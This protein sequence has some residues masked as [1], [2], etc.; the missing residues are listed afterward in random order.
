MRYISTIEDKNIIIKD[1]IDNEEYDVKDLDINEL[2]YIMG[3]NFSSEV[4]VLQE[5]LKGRV[6]FGNRSIKSHHDLVTRIETCY[7]IITSVG[8]DGNISTSPIMKESIIEAETDAI[9][10]TVNNRSECKLV[11]QHPKSSCSI[12]L[13][14]KTG[15]DKLSVFTN[16]QE[17]VDLIISEKD[18]LRIGD[19]DYMNMLKK[20]TSMVLSIEELNRNTS[21]KELIP[22][23]TR[24]L[25][26]KCERF[27]MLNLLNVPHV[28]TY[29]L[30]TNP[31]DIGGWLSK[32]CEYHLNNHT[33]VHIQENGRLLEWFI[34]LDD[35][36]TKFEINTIEN[37]IVIIELEYSEYYYR[38]IEKLDFVDGILHS[39]RPYIK[40][41]K[42]LIIRVDMLSM[43]SKGATVRVRKKEGIE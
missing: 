39:G 5:H 43:R 31:Y 34:S 42:N 26:V 37:D 1:T 32:T 38:K 20:G 4:S 13:R 16:T 28:Y 2:H 25:M 9:V 10:V 17:E 27:S 40:T 8:K 6:E 21:T 29:I 36:E 22:H 15:I 7:E 30:C 35:S 19:L 33:Q 23:R 24:N 12:K 11:L 41:Y 14:I 3:S 18:L